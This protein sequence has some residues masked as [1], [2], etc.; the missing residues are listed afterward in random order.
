MSTAF[1]P[2]TAQYTFFSAAHGTLSKI[3]Y[4]LGHKS[5]LNKYKKNEITPCILSKH[6]AIKL[7]LKT[8]AAEEN[9]QTIG[10]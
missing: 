8:K 10:G 6:N 2:A 4:V 5:S 3:D 1:H 9:T 7:E